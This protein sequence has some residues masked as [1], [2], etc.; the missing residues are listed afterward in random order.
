MRREGE[1]KGGKRER[2]RMRKRKGVRDEEDGMDGRRR[3]R[4]KRRNRPPLAR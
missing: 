1:E 4:M 3:K 2:S